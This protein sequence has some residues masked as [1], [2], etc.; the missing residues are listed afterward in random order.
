MFLIN[1][2]NLKGIPLRY[3]NAICYSEKET[4]N[5]KIVG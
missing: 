3:F 2:L 5:Q 1:K 4:K